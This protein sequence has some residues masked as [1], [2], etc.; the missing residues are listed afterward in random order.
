MELIFEG[1]PEALSEY[2][3]MCSQT[4]SSMKDSIH[5]SITEKNYDLLRYVRHSI[6]PLLLQTELHEL[7]VELEAIKE[8]SNDWENRSMNLIPEFVSIIDAFN[9]RATDV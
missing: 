3:Q 5:Q 2:L 1:N 7:I 4:F 8:D 9:K 6:K